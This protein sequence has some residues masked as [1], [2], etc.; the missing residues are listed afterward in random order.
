MN[1]CDPRVDPRRRI[2]GQGGAIVLGPQKNA[3]IFRTRGLA[4]GP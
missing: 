4:R 2:L 3:M 1:R